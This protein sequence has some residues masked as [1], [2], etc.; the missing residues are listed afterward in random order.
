MAQRISRR[1]LAEYIA[2]RLIDGDATVIEQLAGYLIES[3][4]TKEVDM[5]VYDIEYALSRRG[6]VVAD[7]TSARELA[8]E[9]K[10]LIKQ[11]LADTYQADTTEL[12]QTIDPTLIGGV[13]VRTAD[14]EYDA[15]V[16]RKLTTLQKMKV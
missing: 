4:R 2:D 1:T 15:T 10:T 16:R 9:T 11:F 3:R 8:N 13:K 7:V 6:I 5:Y 12:R 14:T